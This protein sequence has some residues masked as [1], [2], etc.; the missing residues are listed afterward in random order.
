MKKFIKTIFHGRRLVFSVLILAALVIIGAK[1][2]FGKNQTPAYETAMVEKGTIVSSIAISGQIISSNATNV[3]TRASGLVKKIF[4]KDGDRVEKDQ[5]IMEIALD[6]AGQQSNTQAWSSYLSAKN[7]LDS[8]SVTL[9][10]LDSAMWAANRKFVNDALAR[11]LAAIDPTYIQENDDWLAAEAKYKNQQNAIAQSRVSLSNAWL[12]YKLSSPI[13]SAPI[14]GIISG[15]SVV[16]GMSVGDGTG[17]S[18][19]LAVIR[20]ETAPLA[21]FNFSEIDIAK[22]KIDQKATITLD[23]LPGKTFTG[24]VASIDKTGSVS[25]GVTNYPAIIR[26]DLPIPEALP[27]MA[28]NASIIIEAKSDILLVPSQAVQTQ[29][30][31]SVVRALQNGKV[32]EIPV[33]TGLSSETQTEII[34]GLSENEEIII[35]VVSAGSS[36]SSGSSPFG[37]LGTRGMG[38]GGGEFFRSASGGQP[39]NQRRQ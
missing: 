38:G 25:S 6:S 18:Q 2:T 39:G 31:Q 19:K 21:T 16:E 34:S 22:I 4:V 24:K 36:Q 30:G 23:V 3:T 33:E 13:V 17:Q 20:E 11:G 5:K 7:S 37:G 12:S 27:N 35:S 28:V 1:L 15:F 14:S 29:N 32:L 10:S 8:A 26:F 9:W